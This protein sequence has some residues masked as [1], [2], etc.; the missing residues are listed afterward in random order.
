MAGSR[1]FQ[2]DGFRIYGMPAVNFGY[3]SML[4]AK[5][6][7]KA[8]EGDTGETDDAKAH[9]KKRAPRTDSHAA[10][11]KAIIKA[12]KRLNELK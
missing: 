4:T 8:K 9:T 6:I 3:H 7:E 12:A 5:E 2:L 11:A 10:E 1:E